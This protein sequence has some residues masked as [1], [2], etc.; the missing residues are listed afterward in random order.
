MNNDKKIAYMVA[1]YGALQKVLKSQDLVDDIGKP[2][3]VKNKHM[4][5]LKSDSL[6]L[7]AWFAEELK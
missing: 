7:Y 6:K 1:I 2:F 4:T 3:K 5:E